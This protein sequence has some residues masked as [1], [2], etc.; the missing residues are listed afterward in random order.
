MTYSCCIWFN[1]P[2][3]LVFFH[4]T[5]NFCYG[6]IWVCRADWFQ[7][8][9][10]YWCSTSCWWDVYNSPFPGR[11]SES[12]HCCYKLQQQGCW[13]PA[14]CCKFQPFLKIWILFNQKKI[15]VDLIIKCSYKSAR[16]SFI[17]DLSYACFRFHITIFKTL[18]NYFHHVRKGWVARGSFWGLWFKYF[19]L[20]TELNF[21][22]DYNKKANA[23]SWE[24]ELSLSLW[25]DSCFSFLA[26]T[27]WGITTFFTFINIFIFM[28]WLC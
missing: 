15:L 24:T 13:M 18:A 25:R 1:F 19:F 20:E 7:P 8:H 12:S 26:W 17:F 11:I 28:M 21:E 16:Q 3:V 14:S 22:L 2:N 6:Q 9:S 23:I 10:C 5:G 4:M 27:L